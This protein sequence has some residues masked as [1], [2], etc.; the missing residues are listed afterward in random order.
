MRGSIKDV[1]CAQEWGQA[2]VEK[3]LSLTG[4][5]EQHSRESTGR[6]ACV[7]YC[8]HPAV[9]GIAEEKVLGCVPWD[10]WLLHCESSRLS[11][12]VHTGLGG[13]GI[14]TYEG[15]SVTITV[16]IFSDYFCLL[17]VCQAPRSEA[18]TILGALVCFPNTYQGI[19][20]LGPISEASESI[21]G[22]A[23]LKVKPH[24]L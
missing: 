18:H 1:E 15:F 24:L 19:P 4:R 17:A 11:M 20:Q 12:A 3:Q 14:F 16:Y 13:G 22:T 6:K 5:T 23:D 9:A 21:T 8:L 2:P 10:S 7:G